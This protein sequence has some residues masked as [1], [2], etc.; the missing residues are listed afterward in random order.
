MFKLPVLKKFVRG[1]HEDRRGDIPQV[2]LMIGLIAIPIALFL[3]AL[4][5]DATTSTQENVGALMDNQGNLA[6][7]DENAGGAGVTF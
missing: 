4:S 5:D 3:T 1:L 7:Y 2:L 6:E